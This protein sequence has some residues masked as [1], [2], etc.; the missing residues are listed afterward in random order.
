MRLRETS[1]SLSNLTNTPLMQNTSNLFR[2]SKEKRP[3]NV[4]GMQSSPQIPLFDVTV[5]RL[6]GSKDIEVKDRFSGNYERQHFFV[7]VIPT[8]IMEKVKR[9]K[10]L[11]SQISSR[12]NFMITE[13]LRLS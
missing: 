8:V 2:S 9:R 7:K 10:Q 1:G 3:S 5:A 11:K 12:G 13:F 4:V 6:R